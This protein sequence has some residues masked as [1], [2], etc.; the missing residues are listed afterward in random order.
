MTNPNT[1]PSLFD[2]PEQLPV[3]LTLT[4]PEYET[5]SPGYHNSPM[6]LAPGEAQRGLSDAEID[7]QQAINSQGAAAARAV[8]D[9]LRDKS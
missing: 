7:S 3:E 6:S 5:P 9:S 2:S 1:Q 4:K 8:L